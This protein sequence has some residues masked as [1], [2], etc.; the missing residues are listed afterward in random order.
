MRESTS[1]IHV[2]KESVGHGQVGYDPLNH[3]DHYERDHK[4]CKDDNANP[5]RIRYVDVI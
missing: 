5:D 4:S 2:H 3:Y 1:K